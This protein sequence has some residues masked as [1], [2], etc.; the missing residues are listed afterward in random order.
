MSALLLDDAAVGAGA[1]RARAKRDFSYAE[2]TSRNGGLITAKEQARL[3]AGSAF[4]CGVGGMGGAAAIALT[5]A[6][7]GSIVLADPDV[8]EASNLNRQLLATA[9]TLGESKARVTARHL[10]SINPELA[11]E[12]WQSDW[13]GRLSD[14]LRRCPVVVNGMDDVAASLRLYRAAAEHG[15]TVVDA[16]TSPLASVFVVGPSDPRPEARMGFPSVG[17]AIEGL[18]PAELACCALA[19]V[20]WVLA[21]SSSGRYVATE[22]AGA[23][24]SGRARR[25][26]FGPGVLLSGSLMALEAVNA[27]IGRPSGAG[28]AGYFLDPWRGRV[29]RPKAGLRGWLARLRARA[30]VRAYLTDGIERTAPVANRS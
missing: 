15:A 12:A 27:L 6:G 11:V 13:T 25:P 10:R 19:E 5:R 17:R 14:V 16:Y 23:F 30:L 18:G 26:S 28:P 7:I 3:R 21:H 1:A 9:E 4:V 2:M 24:L 8:F 22:A 20:E 29:E